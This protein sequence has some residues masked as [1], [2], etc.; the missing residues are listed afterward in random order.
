[1]FKGMQMYEVQSKVTQPKL[2]NFDPSDGVNTRV[3]IND[4]LGYIEFGA[5]D[6]FPNFL[7]DSVDGSHTASSCIDTLNKF[8]KGSGFEQELL[9]KLDMGNGQTF[10]HL[11]NGISQD[12]GYFEGFYINV[13]YNPLGRI[14]Y[15]NKLPFDLCR[16]GIPNKEDGK[17]S[18]VY[19]NPYFGTS[20]YKEED[21]VIFPIYNPNTPLEEMQDIIELNKELEEDEQLE[22]KGQVLFVKEQRP[23]N[24]FYP[25]PYYW[26]GYRYFEIERKVGEF[27]NENLDNGFFLGGIIK[28][29]GDPN[30]LFSNATNDNGDII[31]NKTVGEAF[32]ERMSEQFS[33]SS[34]TGILM[35]LWSDIKDEFP[36][37]EPFPVNSNND[38]FITLQQLVIDNIPIAYNVPPIIANIQTA[39]KLGGSQEISNA[40]ALVNGKTD[41]RRTKLEETYDELFKNSIWSERVEPVKIIPFGYKLTDPLL[42]DEVIQDEAK[43]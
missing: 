26:S 32:N 40:V 36:E 21:T 28:M 23:Q 10:S 42:I 20:D 18:S 31:S 3:S 35:A 30:E 6:S 25:I 13:R 38:T 37:I 2:Y 39:G 24:K 9:P 33:G 7:L 12:E 41:D 4:S 34:K 17:I 16:L 43:K 8:I 11:H 19:Y 1:M 14:S 5:K 27:H 29:V 15:M 22:Y